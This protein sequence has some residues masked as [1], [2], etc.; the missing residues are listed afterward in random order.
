VNYMFGHGKAELYTHRPASREGPVTGFR[1]RS[2][3]K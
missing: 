3:W 1:D 2:A